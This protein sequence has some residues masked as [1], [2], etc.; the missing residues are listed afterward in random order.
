MTGSSCPPT[1][2]LV[3]RPGPRAMGRPPNTPQVLFL[4]R[5]CDCPLNVPDVAAPQP[6][7]RPWAGAAAPRPP[8]VF[9]CVAQ[10]PCT[11]CLPSIHP[12]AFFVPGIIAPRRQFVPRQSTAS[13]LPPPTFP[14]TVP[15]VHAPPPTV[16]TSPSLPPA[17]ALP[18]GVPIAPAPA[19]PPCMPHPSRHPPLIR[20]HLT[21]YCTMSP[22]C[23]FE[24]PSAAAAPPVLAGNTRAFPP[25]FYHGCLF[26]FMLHKVLSRVTSCFRSSAAASGPGASGPR[27][28][29]GMCRC[30]R[31]MRWRAAA[32]RVTP[33]SRL[34]SSA[35]LASSPSTEQQQ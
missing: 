4:P 5:L 34:L 10:H 31:A 32:R 11:P 19:L 20:A 21:D 33:T 29:G 7:C 1:P 23:C 3:T 6:G 9:P 27:C 35:A 28:I 14:T 18:Q 25:C 13:P 15:D 8:R 2:E 22:L 16:T 30:H 12:V 24:P 26:A 17:A